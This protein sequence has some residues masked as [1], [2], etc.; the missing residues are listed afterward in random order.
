MYELE[1]VRKRKRKIRAAIIG[2]ISA[3]GVS[4]LVIV[5]FL[6]RFVGTFTV[7]LEANNVDIS[8]SEKQSGPRSS[9]LRIDSLVPFQEFT[10][11]E[12]DSK[13][14]DDVIDN[15]EYGYDLGANYSSKN[16]DVMESF[17][18]FK[19][20]FYL[21][22]LGK[23][24]IEYTFNLN[25]IE[26]IIAPDGRNLLDTLRV[27]IYEDGEK[28]IYGKAEE[29]PH[30][31]EGG[32]PSYCPPIST[33]VD[34]D[35]FMGYVDKTFSSDETIT[36]LTGNTLDI[37]KTRRYTIVTWLEGFRSSGYAPIGA[38]IKLGV[39]INAYEI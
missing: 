9:F 4:V 25:V 1:Y 30:Y 17:D 34:D 12:F 32:E 31:N 37:G 2:G 28:N 3:I 23:A 39:E 14:G 22:N 7:S 35:D 16:P 26:S 15:E 18:F 36:S 19:Y 13:Y 11:S 29:V 8:L 10:Y 6:G 20:T 5:A 21:H 38:T 27:M 24:D 33:S